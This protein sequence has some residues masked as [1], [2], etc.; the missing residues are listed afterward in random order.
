MTD[1][2]EDLADISGNNSAVSRGTVLRRHPYSVGFFVVCIGVFLAVIVGA[3]E[4]EILGLDFGVFHA[5]GTLISSEGYAAAYD[6]TG[7][8]AF[9]TEEYFPQWAQTDNVAH[10]IS[11]PTFGWFAQPLALFPFGT[12]LAV[13][14]VFGFIALIPACRILE[15]PRWAPLALAISPM[16]AFNVALGQTGAFVLLLFAAWHV[17][18]R[19]ANVVAAG[20]LGGLL[21]LKPPLAL[22]YGLLWLLQAKRYR[23]SIAI[24]A[25]VG[26]VLSIPTLAG[27]IS[28]WQSFLEAMVQRTEAESAWAQQSG[29]FS[30][31]VKQLTPGAP[32]AVTV[33]SWLLG[34][35][36]A[37]VLLVMAKRRFGND[38]EVLSAA[39]AI[40]TVVASPHLLV[41]DSLILVIPLAVAHR[42]GVLTKDRAG[43]LALVIVGSIALGPTLFGVQYSL[44]GR[45]LGVEFLALSAATVLLACWLGEDAGSS[46]PLR[47]NDDS[48]PVGSALS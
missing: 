39:A 32:T 30:E 37:G 33:A 6:T 38:P 27:G 1:V 42:R 7:F 5:G 47:D 36:A 23:L 16:M 29:S 34:L 20:L 10:F 46:N 24:A 2:L 12:M 26:A 21:I 44:I 25:A 40:G 19:Q 35:L 31:F 48:V 9:F 18:H 13:W 22:G 4:M 17:A 11:T 43:L 28:P 3:L 41:Y 14:T 8:S 15:L 45:G